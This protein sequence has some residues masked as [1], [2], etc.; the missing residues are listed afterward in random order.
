M[1]G[2]RAIV[3]GAGGQDGSY[4]V[5][6]LRSR[7]YD[8]LGIQHGDVDLTDVDAVAALLRDA[9]PDELY[10]LASPSFVPRSWEQPLQT[11]HVGVTAVTAL[12]EAVR[13]VEP[14]IRLVHAS[15]AEVFGVPTETPQRETT[16]IRPRSPYGAAKAYGTFLI[17]AYRERYGLH[18]SSAILFN[19]ESPR[20]S[21]DFVP[22]KIAHAATAIAA[23]RQN[24]LVLGDLDARRD[25]GYAPD[26]VHAMWLMLQQ[27]DPDDFVIATGE[28]HTVQ[29]LVE[30]AFAHV[31]LEWRD[32]VRVDASLRRGQLY[33]LVGDATKARTRLGWQ[34][35][36]TF[37][38]LVALLVDAAA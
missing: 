27:E 35:S 17:A 22:A 28:L 12:L 23:G 2:A 16:P 11:A 31:G 36:V 14:S 6:L 38:E 25:W 8:V 29:E 30:I 32:H 18:V 37:E 9:A 24:E 34:P 21:T 10:N 20:R 1:N 3:T 4:L 5:E 13:R 7:D 33:E 19:H 15:S 26:Y